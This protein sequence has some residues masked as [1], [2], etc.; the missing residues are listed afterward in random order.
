MKYRKESS[1]IPY[2]HAMQSRGSSV[3]Q[4]YFSR[5]FIAVSIQNKS[6]FFSF[7]SGTD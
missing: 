6:D 1:L 7:L 4:Y 3:A 2:H 5:S